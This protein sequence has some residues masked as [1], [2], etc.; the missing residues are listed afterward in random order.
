MG[1]LHSWVYPKPCGAGQGEAGQGRVGW[2]GLGFVCTAGLCTVFSSCTNADQLFKPL[3]RLATAISTTAAD[4][5]SQSECPQN[6]LGSA[7]TRLG[8]LTSVAR[9]DC[10]LTFNVCWD[11]H[12]HKVTVGNCC[13]SSNVSIWLS[14]QYFLHAGSQL[15]NT[16]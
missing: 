8:W 15:D 11:L 5:E 14:E 2:I 13:L 12:R 7:C 3:H 10:M 1:P 9:S 4:G 6:T 16:G